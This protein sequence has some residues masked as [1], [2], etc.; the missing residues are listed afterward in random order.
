V[1]R[2][3]VVYPQ[4]RDR[5]LL[6][7][8]SRLEEA[9]LQLKRERPILQIVDRT[10]WE[11]VLEE[12]RIQLSGVV[13]DETASRIGGFLGADSILLYRLTTPSA[14][15]RLLAQFYGDQVEVVIRSKIIQVATG[16]VIFYNVVTIRT[17]Q[18][19][20][21]RPF[22]SFSLVPLLDRGIAQTVADLHLA[23]Q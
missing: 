9:A 4:T 12:Q 2:L 21:E 7:A 15:D 16:E 14:R 23:F 13:S 3:A 11:I 5:E 10:D 17:E 19:P 22:F 18:L 20:V 6:A 1:V 8:Y